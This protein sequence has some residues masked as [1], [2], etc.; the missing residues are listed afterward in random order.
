MEVKLQGFYSTVIRLLEEYPAQF[1]KCAEFREKIRDHENQLEICE[2]VNVEDFK[3][4]PISVQ[5]KAKLVQKLRD[6]ITDFHVKMAE[7][8]DGQFRANSELLKIKLEK[9]SVLGI[10]PTS[11]NLILVQ[12]YTWAEEI[13]DIFEK[14]ALKCQFLLQNQHKLQ[15]EENSISESDLIFGFEPRKLIWSRNFGFTNEETQKINCKYFC[16]SSKM[17]HTVTSK[18]IYFIFRL[19]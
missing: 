5:I 13:S 9:C 2:K 14:H 10:Q 12:F 6:K 8:I 11:E 1:E 15:T 4:E 18:C 3:C 17:F 19:L 7:I 16:D